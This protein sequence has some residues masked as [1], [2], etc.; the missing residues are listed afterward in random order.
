M[1]V[2]ESGIG[3]YLHFHGPKPSRRVPVVLLYLSRAYGG[4]LALSRR[5]CRNSFPVICWVPTSW[6]YTLHSSAATSAFSLTQKLFLLLFVL[7]LLL[8]LFHLLS[9]F[10][11]PSPFTFNLRYLSVHHRKLRSH[12]HIHIQ[13][14]TLSTTFKMVKAGT[15]STISPKV[16][17]SRHRDAQNSLQ[18]LTESIVKYMF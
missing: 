7:L 8:F 1:E 14:N 15:S 3:T 5:P 9:S 11:V 10:I 4:C 17:C 6:R 18:Y 13:I 2:V 12:P 16:A